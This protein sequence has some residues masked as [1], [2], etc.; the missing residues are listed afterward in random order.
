MTIKQF[1]HG[2]KIISFI[3][4]LLVLVLCLWYIEFIYYANIYPD[5]SVKT[6]YTATACTLIQ[7]K[8]LA[9]GQYVH[10]YRA[11]FLMKFVVEGA[12]YQ[13]WASANGLDRSFTT[14]LAS[15]N[16][17]LMRFNIQKDYPCWY[18]PEVPQ[19]VVL[20]M[21]NN[22]SATFPLFIPAVIGIMMLY[23]SSR[24][25]LGLLGVTK[26]YKK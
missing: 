16:A 5:Q 1:S 12:Q 9:H 13:A 26:S 2:R 10:R 25:L 19:L 21:R 11:D 8:L 3:A 18:N 20:V 6:T 15:Q 17:A 14:D 24:N 23:F 7:K 4:Q 22:W